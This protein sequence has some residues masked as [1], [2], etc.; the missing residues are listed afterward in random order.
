MLYSGLIS[1][2]PVSNVR[3]CHYPIL[4]FIIL[5]RI[6]VNIEKQL[7]LSLEEKASIYW[8]WTT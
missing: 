3:D 2:Y 7:I 4:N 6:S 1:Y 5:L 8:H